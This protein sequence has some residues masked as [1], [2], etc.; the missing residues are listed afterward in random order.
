MG[1][2][3]ILISA[4]AVRKDE[5]T[6]IDNELVAMGPGNKPGRKKEAKK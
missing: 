3:K 2:L 5:K 6:F 4:I 1:K